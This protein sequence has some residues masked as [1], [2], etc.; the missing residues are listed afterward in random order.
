M[1][2]ELEEQLG[3]RKGKDTRDA[4]GLIPT[5]GERY[6]EKDKDVHKI[7]RWYGLASR[8]WKDA[9]EHAH[10]A[11]WKMWCLWDEDKYK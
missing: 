4:I 7:C 11:K 9:E 2:D 10:G 8:R 3:F 1:E 5:I 6:I